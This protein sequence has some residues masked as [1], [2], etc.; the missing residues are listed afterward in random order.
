M[1]KLTLLVVLLAAVGVAST[2]TADDLFRMRDDMQSRWASFENPL[3]E[4]GKGGTANRGGKGAAFEPVKA[5]ETKVLMDVQGSGT[6]HRMWFTLRSRDPK[7]LRSYVLRFYWDNAQTPAVE[8]PFGDFFGHVLGR[9]TAFESELFSSPEGRS[10]NAF[11]P[12]PFRTAAKAT[13]TNESDEDL[14][15]LFYDIN[16][17]LNDEHDDDVLYFHATWRRE[18]WTELGRDFEILPKVAGRGRFLGANIGVI[19]GPGNKGWWGEGEVKMY[20]DGDGELPTI[21]GTGTE[22]YIGTAYGQGVYNNRYQG[23]WILDM[24]KEHFTFYRQHVPDPIFFHEDMRVTIQQMGGA[25][26]KIVQKLLKEGVEIQPV[27]VHNEEEMVFL[28]DKDPPIDL[29]KDETILDGWT[30]MYRRDDVCAVALFYLD[31][32]ENGLPRIAPIAQ[33][34][35]AIE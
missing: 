24:E 34:I 6:V 22:D 32:P 2:A 21:V 35:E 14:E 8:V 19:G 18:R 5:G 3:G 23:C 9:M 11:I 30:N 13:F 12:M 10:L 7:S 28:L 25:D 17:S 1:F 20:L 16:Y 29:T 4:K 31:R 15:Q 26:K 33:R 27:T